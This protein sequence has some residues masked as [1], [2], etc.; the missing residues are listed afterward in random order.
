[1]ANRPFGSIGYANMIGFAL[2]VPATILSAP[3]GAKI[4]HTI[5]TGGLRKAFALFLFLTSLRMIYSLV[6]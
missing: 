1:M 2:I 4:A 5:S 3:Y 6:A